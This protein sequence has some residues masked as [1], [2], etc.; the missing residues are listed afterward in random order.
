MNDKDKEA[1]DKW[2]F[3]GFKGMS[4]MDI[5]KYKNVGKQSSLNGWQAA[6]EHK[7]KEIDEL[8]KEKDY[9]CQKMENMRLI[10]KNSEKLQAENAK[11]RECVEFYC[12][13]NTIMQSADGIFIRQ[14]WDGNFFEL[15]EYARQVLKELE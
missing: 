9:L 7:Q 14:G 13:A 12:N 8:E 11:L 15:R 5:I 6:C 1:F 4:D 2:W 10:Y 3:N